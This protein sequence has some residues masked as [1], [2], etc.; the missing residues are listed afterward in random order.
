MAIAHVFGRVDGVDVILE[1]EGDRWMVPVPLDQDGEYAVE[2]VA[3]DDAGNQSY[4]AKLLFCVNAAMLC[5]TILPEPYYA[6]LL[7]EVFMAE[8]LPETFTAE[9]MT[10]CC[11]KG[12]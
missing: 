9:L 7:P 2:I 3:E 1:Q 10:T 4:M 6:E 11:Q 5:V 8:L 12:G